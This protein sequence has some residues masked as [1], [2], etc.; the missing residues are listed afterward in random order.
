MR[1]KRSVLR[2]PGQD[3]QVRAARSVAPGPTASEVHGMVSMQGQQSTPLP[4]D[5]FSK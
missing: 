3:R 1:S 4:Q 5:T 2:A